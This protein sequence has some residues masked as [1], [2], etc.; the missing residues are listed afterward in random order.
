MSNEYSYICT[1]LWRLSNESARECILEDACKKRHFQ[2]HDATMG[3]NGDFR[4][5]GASSCGSSEAASLD[6]LDSSRSASHEVNDQAASDA[7][8]RDRIVGRETRKVWLWKAVVVLFILVTASGVI[9]S[10]YIFLIMSEHG[11]FIDAVRQRQ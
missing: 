3:S 8:L 9:T 11:E 5:S 2:N 10:T 7:R 1:G 4:C 6:L